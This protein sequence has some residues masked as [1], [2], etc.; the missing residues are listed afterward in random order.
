[1]IALIA[2]AVIT[3]LVIVVLVVMLLL[4]RSAGNAD[5]QN[6]GGGQTSAATV[7]ETV[8]AADTQEAETADTVD[9]QETEAADAAD[10]QADEDEDD[11]DSNEDAAATGLTEI[12]AEAIADMQEVAE[13]VLLEN[14]E[15]NLDAETE[16][17]VT[18]QYIGYYYMTGKDGVKA[19][20]ANKIFLL[21]KVLVNDTF[22]T[23]SGEQFNENTAYYWYCRFADLTA[24]GEDWEVD[25][26]DYK[27][28]DDY[29]YTFTV[30]SGLSTYA[31]STTQTWQYHGFETL[32]IAY[33]QLVSANEAMYDCKS[34]V[35]DVTLDGE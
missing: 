8:D 29:R 11:V 1:M 26:E 7:A 10:T 19:D 14:A 34:Y 22:T 21:Y 28:S 20:P 6:A 31:Y 35:E 13:R 4:R 3:V 17:L 9:T 32:D 12:P 25:L 23:N 27:T 30:D 2:I 33:S 5:T 24:S 15:A 16:S 18:S